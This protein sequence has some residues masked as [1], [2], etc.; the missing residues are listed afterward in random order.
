[1]THPKLASGQSG[2]GG[3]GYRIPG[4]TTPHGKQRVDPSVTTVLKHVAKPGLMQWAA[5]QTA[6]FAVTNRSRLNDLADERA[7]AFLRFYWNREPELAGSDLRLFHEGVRDDSA[8]IG[9]N[10]HE[11]IEAELTDGHEVQPDSVE[12]EQMLVVWDAWLERHEIRPHYAEFSVVNDWG[13]GIN[14]YAGTADADWSIRCVHDGP[15]CLG[16]ARGEWARTLIDVKTSRYTWKEHGMQL[17]AL[18]DAPISMVEVAEGTPGAR[19]AEKTE[20]G[21]KVRSWWLERESPAYDRLA[22]LHIRP[23]DLDPKGRRIEAFC[24]LVDRTRDL[25]LYRT[26][27]KGALLLAQSAR[28]LERRGDFRALAGL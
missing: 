22:L 25:D 13:Y 6:A 18:F 16:Q 9:T 10:V 17:A 12:A 28:E 20:D 11:I 21:R 26:G 7:W 4:R 2:W 3:R 5:D 8:D 24:E 14:A 23:H 15:A 1:M 27:F 19:K